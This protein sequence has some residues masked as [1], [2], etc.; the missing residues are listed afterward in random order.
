[1]GSCWPCGWPCHSPCLHQRFEYSSKCW[2]T[3]V[4]I[5]LLLIC[6]C[7]WCHTCHVL[8]HEQSLPIILATFPMKM[9]ASSKCMHDESWVLDR[10]NLII[11]CYFLM[12][13]FRTRLIF[14]SFFSKGFFSYP[15]TCIYAETLQHY[16]DDLECLVAFGSWNFVWILV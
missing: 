13:C 5:V 7:G 1:M 14:V 16:D 11:S 10:E 12:V 2:G 8:C 4:V 9:L 6:S 15:E 3:V